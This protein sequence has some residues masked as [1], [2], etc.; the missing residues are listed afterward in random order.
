MIERASEVLPERD[1]RPGV[2]RGK[3]QREHINQPA[4]AGRA[5]QD[6][7]HEREP[8]GQFAVGDEESDGPGVREDEIL[9]HGHHKGI[10]AAAVEEAVDPELEAAA[11]GELRA[12]DF[13]LAENQEEHADSDAQ[14]GESERIAVR[15]R[16]R[17]S[18]CGAGWN[19]HRH[20]RE[21][22]EGGRR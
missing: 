11:E 10:S 12:K 3:Q 17:G 2:V 7:Q 13:V 15:A 8:D 20:S 21:C 18:G 22:S 1:V 9:Q 4:N 19:C 5:H 14:P 6:A 16:R